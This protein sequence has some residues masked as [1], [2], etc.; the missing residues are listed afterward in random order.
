MTAIALATTYPLAELA[1]A[2]AVI[3]DLSQVRAQ[4]NGDSRLEVVVG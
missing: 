4:L 2:D 3:R 1:H